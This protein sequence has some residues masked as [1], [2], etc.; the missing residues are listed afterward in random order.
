MID[1]FEIISPLFSSL[2][3]LW[4]FF[5]IILVMMFLKTSYAKGLIGEILVNFIINIKLDK[6]KYHL[7]KNVTFLTKDGTT[8]VDH[9]L[10]S[11]FGIFVIETKN[12]K[13]WI[14]GDKNQKYW[15][16]KIYKFS[17]KFQNP[18]FQNYKH[19]KTIENTL[20]IEIKKLFSLIVFVGDSTFKTPMP[21]NVTYRGDFIKF[22]KSKIE[23]LFSQKEVEN[24]ILM[25]EENR[26]SRT[27]KTNVKHIK[28]VKEIIKEKENLEI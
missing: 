26:L 4:Y 24:I 7:I 21:E 17:N 15:T 27:I 22:I 8:Q 2:L 19:I 14:L 10:V 13:G 23:V 1:L 25:I 11:Q 28:H 20:N 18:L 3:E 9:I 16:Q 12:M 6:N 5:P